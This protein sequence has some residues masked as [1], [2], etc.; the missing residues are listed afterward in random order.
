[1]GDKA[2]RFAFDM[3]DSDLREILK[4]IRQGK[5][6][7]DFLIAT[8][9]AHEPDNW[10]EEPA[11]FLPKL[12]HAAIDAGA[13]VFI[14]HG[15][16]RLRPIEIYQGKPIFY[17]LGN[18]FFQVA[19][20]EPVP[21]DLY[22]AL[23][24]DPNALTENEIMA[25]LLKAW[26]DAPVWYRSVIAVSRFEHGQIAE[27]RLYPVDLGPTAGNVNQGI[28]RLATPTVAETILEELQRL[29][30]PYGTTIAIEDGVGIIRL[31]K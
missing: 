20:Q 9:H 25:K 1:M 4:G 13:D 3:N 10:S 27:V 21:T 29:S 19:V 17:S 30:K 5:Q 24:G 8:I 12:A 18:F 28:P 7:S 26:F 23:K 31:R 14:G 22:D 2:V 6:N 16:H 15:P 11:D